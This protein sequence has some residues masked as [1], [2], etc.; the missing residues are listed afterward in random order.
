MELAKVSRFGINTRIVSG[1]NVAE[2]VT[3]EEV[4]ALGGK[5][6]FVVT[7]EGVVA[8]GLVQPITDS[9]TGQGMEFAVYDGVQPNPT[10]EVVDAGYTKLREAGCDSVVAIGGGSS[11][12]AA[13]AIAVL[14]TN[15][16]KILD[17]EG[18]NKFTELPAPLLAI[19]TTCGTGSEVT[20]GAVI[21]DK[22]RRIKTIVAGV[23]IRPKVAILDPTLLVTLPS[24]ITAATGLDALTHAIESYLSLAG[25]PL[26]DALSLGAVEL[27]GQNLRRAVANNDLDALGDM[28]MAST[29]AGM[30]FA[31]SRLGIIHAITDILGGMYDVPHGVACAILL[32]HAMRFNL[33]GAAGKFARIASAMGEITEWLTPLEAAEMAVDTV[34]S[35][36]DDLGLPTRLRD[37]GVE[38]DGFSTVVE[39]GMK[40]PHIPVNPRRPT[41]DDLMSVL[42]QAY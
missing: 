19:P 39:S 37:I 9:L 28:L 38:E 35:L 24:P 21:S 13:K 32:P 1:P 42:R 20:H 31:N 11:I 27:I 23:A 30:A 2:K 15:G 10:T 4:A 25:T 8:A 22:K 18:L 36:I 7:D 33:I 14:V 3:G 41:P 6:A 29:M 17:Y 5:K 26:T 34:A 40:S 16:G 12:D